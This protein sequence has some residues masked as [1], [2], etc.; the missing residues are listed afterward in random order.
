[1][2]VFLS[3]AVAVRCVARRPAS[4]LVLFGCFSSCSVLD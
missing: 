1:M 4:W 2:F 3:Q